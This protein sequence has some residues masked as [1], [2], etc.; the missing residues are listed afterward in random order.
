MGIALGV[1]EGILL[2][3]VVVGLLVGIFDG[4]LLGVRVGVVGERVGAIVEPYI[5]RMAL[6]AKVFRSAKYI[7]PSVSPAIPRGPIILMVKAGA[8]YTNADVVPA[9][10]PAIVLI[11]SLKL[12]RNRI[13]LLPASPKYRSPRVFPHMQ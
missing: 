13:N 2:G 10:L 3:V 6:W 12:L 9:P 8:L 1:A 5:P 7:R 11:L 4:T